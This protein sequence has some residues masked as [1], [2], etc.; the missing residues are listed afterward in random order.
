MMSTERRRPLKVGVQLPEVERVVPWPE[1]RDMAVR[2][3]QIGFDSIWV[4]D[5]LIYRG[6]DDS[7]T[8]PWEAWT[9]L[10][11]L[12]AVTSRVEIGPL[13]A[14]TSFHAPA[15][16]AK[17]AITLDEV[18]QGRFI[19]GLGAGWNETEYQAFGFPFTN[20]VSRFAEA[21]DI[22]RQL[23]AGQTLDHQGTYYHVTQCRIVPPGPRP[24][25]P[26]LMVGSMGP[27]MLKL[28]MPYVQMWNAWY[29]WFDN[30][31][32][33]LVPILQQV[34]HVCEGV[35]RDPSEIVRT[36]TLLVQTPDGLGR[37]AGDPTHA[38][39]T[40][41]SGTA[42]QVAEAIAQYAALGIHHVQLV[43]DPINI[44]SIE[45][46]GEVLDCLDKG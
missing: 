27:R 46:C 43:I 5:H 19:L 29:Q 24:L 23:I 13:V 30:Q 14:A 22:I 6:A 10:A 36:I 41:I 7:V 9:L 12:A 20:R 45:W 17:K 1:Y 8:G 28:T 34:D 4:G 38:S 32:Q 33:Q 42:A 25:G 21:F 11:A 15:M 3:E 18:S 31:P 37:T 35:G 16:I 26:P 39:A 44:A 2:A 40:P